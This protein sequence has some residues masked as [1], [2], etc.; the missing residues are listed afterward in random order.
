MTK[1]SCRHCPPAKPCLALRLGEAAWTLGCTVLLWMAV[2]PLCALVYCA[3]SLLTS[4][5]RAHFVDVGR[6]TAGVW[7]ASGARP[8]MIFG[9]GW[10]LHADDR[11]K[12]GIE[13]MISG[14]SAA[15]YSLAP[16]SEWPE[17]KRLLARCKALQKERR[18]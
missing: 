1:T 11:R 2:S 4:V 6:F 3:L 16:R 18:S 7:K 12:A 14:V 10:I 8:P 17:H 15:V 13:F 5:R 9:L